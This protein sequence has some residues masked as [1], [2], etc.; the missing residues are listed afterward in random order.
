MAESAPCAVLGN[1]V[2]TWLLR[3]LPA[4]T[5]GFTVFLNPPLTTLSK[6]CLAALLP[7]VFVFSIAG[8]EVVGAVVVLAGMW[9]ALS[10]SLRAPRRTRRGEA[11]RAR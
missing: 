2:W 11:P 4:S 1:A 8:R 7:G 10:R 6:W 5:V 3:H 9:I